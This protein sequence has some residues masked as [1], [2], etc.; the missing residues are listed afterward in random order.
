MAT[1]AILGLGN[2][3]LDISVDVPD[4]ALCNKYGLKMGDA[5]LATAEHAPL[6]K[7]ITAAPFTPLYVAGG[8]TLNSIRVSQWISGEPAGFSA[9]IG[10]I[11]ADDF[12]AQLQASAA[13]DKVATLFEVQPAGGK[14]TGTCAVLILDKERSLC[15][16]LVAAEALTAAHLDTPAVQAAIASA[17]I[18]YTAGFPLTHDGGAESALRLGKIAVEQ[19]KTYALN[20]SAPFITQVPVRAAPL[21]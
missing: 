4:M 10:S 5:A 19:G 11:G 16:N 2:P 14:P 3:L 7:E 1:P 9:F 17:K 20:L 6:Y 15:A 21:P 8:A 13:A 18:L 12:G